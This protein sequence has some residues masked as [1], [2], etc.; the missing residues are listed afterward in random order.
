MSAPHTT[1]LICASLAYDNIML[2][3]DRFSNHILPDKMHMLNVSFLVEDLRREFG[4]CAGNIAYNLQLLR[5]GTALPMST[6]GHD[7]APYSEW[8]RQQGISQK[9]IS[10]IQDSYTAQAYI[11][12]DLDDNQITAFHAGAM[13]YAHRNPIQS[14]ADMQIGLIGPDGKQGMLEHAG[15]LAANDIPFLFD[16][17]QGT[18]M[19][20]G[21]ELCTLLD[22]ATWVAANDYEWQLIEQRTGL[23]LSQAATRV[24]GIF[25][26]RGAGGSLVRERKAEYLVPALA[27]RNIVDPTGCGDAY[28]A[29]LL[30]GLLEG[31][32]LQS[33]ARI[34]TLLGGI[35]IEHRGTQNHRFDMQQLQEL[36]H[37]HFGMPLP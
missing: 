7:F 33:C 17:G 16:P 25:I 30:H 5:P 9:Y 26:T 2:F 34:A 11:T 29:G 32:D 10:I 36:H 1:A 20:D 24:Q 18:P 13:N 8:I 23:S 22:Q 37:A 27:G 15:Q 19:F 21:A 14:T 12:T 28:R 3:R 6:V 4:G 35:K 31:M